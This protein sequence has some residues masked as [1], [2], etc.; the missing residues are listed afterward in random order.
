MPVSSVATLN[1][2]LPYATRPAAFH[3]AVERALDA[4]AAFRPDLLLVSAGFDAWRDDPIGGL[5]L[6]VEDFARIGATVRAAARAACGGRVV[7]LLEGG[8][9]LRA[10][11]PCVGAYL[12]GLEAPAT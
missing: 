8:Y 11:G 2:P 12:D 1:L 6:D 10:L 9:D 5:H 4:C 3:G 7:S